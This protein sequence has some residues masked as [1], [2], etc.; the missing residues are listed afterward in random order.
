MRQVEERPEARRRIAR[1]VDEGRRR[2]S[3]G[4]L[5]LDIEVVGVEEGTEEGIEIAMMSE[6]RIGRG[7]IR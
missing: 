1:L 7:V 4:V 2:A 6:M 3:D 5:G